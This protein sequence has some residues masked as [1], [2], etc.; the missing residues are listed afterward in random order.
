[1]VKQHEMPLPYKSQ[2]VTIAWLPDTVSRFEDKIEAQAKAYNIDANLVA[3]VMTL[4]SGGFTKADSGVANGLMQ[5]TDPTGKD[6]A[7]MYLKK[8]VE[9]FDLYAVDTSIEF[10]TA[11]LAHLRNTLCDYTDGPSWNACVEVVTAGY[12]GGPGAAINLASGKGLLDTQTVIY[13]RNAYNMWRERNGEASPT[14]NR[15]LDAGGQRLVDKAREE[16]K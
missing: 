2:G 12:N 14:F 6:I 15:W 13:S 1:M 16:M 10:G 11:Y 3:I 7:K 9:K 8:P 4:E 5:V